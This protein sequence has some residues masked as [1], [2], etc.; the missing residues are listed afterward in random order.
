MAATLAEVLGIHEAD[1]QVTIEE[2]PKKLQA[3]SFCRDLLA[4]PEYRASLL[5]RIILDELPPAVECKLMD[6]A[7]GKPVERVAITHEQEDL[8][9]LTEEQLLVRLDDARRQL[10]ER[11]TGRATMATP[12]ALSPTVQ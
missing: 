7:W 6:Y 12:L 10:I 4:S 2:R 8:R 5:R 11:Q 3:K 9:A 1:E